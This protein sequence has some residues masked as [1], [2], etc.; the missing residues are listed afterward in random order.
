MIRCLPLLLC[1]LLSVALPFEALAA[2][3][4]FDFKTEK[5]KVEGKRS[6]SI[7]MQKMDEKWAYNVEIDNHSFKDI[8]GVEIKY[9]VFYKVVQA[10]SKVEK[11]KRLSGSATA[12]VLKNNAQFTFQT[13][14]IE[15]I[16]TQL[17]GG[18]YWGNGAKTRSRD[19]L[20]GIWVRIF[21]NGTMIGEYAD[22]S[23]LTSQDWEAKK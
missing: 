7:D 2:D 18:F 15:L 11:D 5:K 19:A 22:P 8:S 12:A 3:Y 14:P 13:D 16:K 1:G 23:N 17:I 21:Q 9:V 4:S 10:G 20:T 6:T